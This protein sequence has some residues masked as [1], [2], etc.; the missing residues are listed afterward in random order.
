[1]TLLRSALLTRQVDI[2]HHARYVNVPLIALHVGDHRMIQCGDVGV[3]EIANQNGGG[4]RDG[5]QHSVAV[6]TGSL[7]DGI[8]LREKKHLHNSCVTC[9]EIDHLRERKSGS[10]SEQTNLQQ[11]RAR[12]TTSR[13]LSRSLYFT[14]AVTCPKKRSI[15]KSTSDKKSYQM[16]GF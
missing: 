6:K 10:G 16:T 9:I 12:R 15:M 1:M 8:L 4:Q 2:A 7:K 14:L 3:D 11:Q 5:K 13:K